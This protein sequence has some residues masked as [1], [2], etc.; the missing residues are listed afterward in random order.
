M[1]DIN[2]N[3]FKRTIRVCY[4]AGTGTLIIRTEL[5][6]EQDVNPGALSRDGTTATFEIEAR[7]RFVHFKP[8]LVKNGSLHWAVGPDNLLMMAGEDARP[9]YPYFFSNSRGRFSPIVQIQSAI[10]GRHHRLR[11][12]LPPGYDENTT[13]H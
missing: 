9:V 10:L 3:N 8:C 1:A 2:K 4:P 7:Q 11:I 6:W 13:A 12:Y 5:N